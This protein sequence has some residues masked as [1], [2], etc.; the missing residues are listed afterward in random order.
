MRRENGR[1]ERQVNTQNPLCVCSAVAPPAQE[2]TQCFGN[3]CL[4]VCMGVFVCVTIVSP[5]TAAVVVFPPFAR[6]PTSSSAVMT[7]GGG[8]AVCTT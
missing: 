5:E 1:R 3:V 2:F 6:H 4:C 8:S 7:L